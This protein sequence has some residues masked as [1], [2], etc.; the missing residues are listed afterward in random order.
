[1]K[2]DS[3][4]KG[5]CY[6]AKSPITSV[7]SLYNV[8]LI[9]V[10]NLPQ[11]VGFIAEVFGAVSDNGINIDMISQT[12]PI[13][14]EVCISFTVNDEDMFKA[15]GCLNSLKKITSL[16]I[17]VDP[18]N[19]MIVIAGKNIKDTPGV[20]TSIFRLMAENNIDI[21]II[22]TSESDITLLVYEKDSQMAES[23]IRKE[24]I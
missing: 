20:A 1:M 10:C 16:S 24:F 7:K 15:I 14:G 9:T 5:G 12:P 4:K 2:F 17:D 8:A 22:T 11:E 18:N 6:M 23:L 21:K 3:I 13:I 19:V